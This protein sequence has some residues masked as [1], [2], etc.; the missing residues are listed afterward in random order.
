MP[1]SRFL[2]IF[3]IAASLAAAPHPELPF[4]SSPPAG[5]PQRFGCRTR[6][7]TSCLA[8]NHVTPRSK[9]GGD[10]ICNLGLPCGHCNF[11]K[12]NRGMECLV[13]KIAAWGHVL[14]QQAR[15]SMRRLPVGW[16]VWPQF[17]QG[18]L[19]L[20]ISM[21][22]PGGS[23]GPSCSAVQCMP[24]AARLPSAVH[25]RPRSSSLVPGPRAI[26]LR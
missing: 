3:A 19:G 7:K 2:S 20:S 22:W 11:V 12:G 21:S 24:A 25:S 9:G 1:H 26:I 14:Y 10:H 6:F 17:E 18:R 5:R 15:H 8:V 13:A 23:I 16:N 4:T